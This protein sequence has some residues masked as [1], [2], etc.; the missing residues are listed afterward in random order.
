MS[1]RRLHSRRPELRNQTGK[2]GRCEWLAQHGRSAS[3]GGPLQRRRIAEGAGENDA[4]TWKKLG[5]SPRRLDA[6][7]VRKRDRAYDHSHVLPAFRQAG[8]LKKQRVAILGFYHAQSMLVHDP[9]YIPSTRLL[10]VGH[11]SNR[12]IVRRHCAQRSGSVSASVRDNCPTTAIALSW[13]VRRRL[14]RQSAD[15]SS[16]GTVGTRRL[17]TPSRSSVHSEGVSSL[18]AYAREH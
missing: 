10:G 12:R 9:H 13:S 6:I 18:R 3:F 14:R 16:G 8:R 7:A 5:E 2:L 11:E 4:Q 15:S 1:P 17:H